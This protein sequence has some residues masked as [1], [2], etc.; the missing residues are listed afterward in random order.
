MVV[1]PVQPTLKPRLNSRQLFRDGKTVEIDH[2]EQRYTLRVT[3]DNKL[4]LTK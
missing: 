3:K 4:I 2:G 1:V